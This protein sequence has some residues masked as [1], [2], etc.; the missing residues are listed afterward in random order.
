MKWIHTSDLHIGKQI[1][2]FFSFGGSAFF[3]CSNWLHWRR[4]SVRM[5]FY[6]P[7]ILYD[8]FCSVSRSGKRI[9]RIFKLYCAYLETSPYWPLQANHDSPQRLDFCRRLF[10]NVRSVP[11][12]PLSKILGSGLRFGMI[13]VRFIFICVP[14]WSPPLVRADFPDR[15]LRSFG[16][17]IRR[18]FRGKRIPDRFFPAKCHFG[19]RLF[20]PILKNPDSVARSES[21][22]SLGGSDLIDAKRLEDF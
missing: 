16:R 12:R 21:E 9:R 6:F 13:W 7:E 15:D 4:R 10:T 17:C 3:F 20:F 5:H 14:T 19:S 8:R 11:F 18:C 22:V 2:E 1:N